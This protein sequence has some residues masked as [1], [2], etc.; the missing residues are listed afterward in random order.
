MIRTVLYIALKLICLTAGLLFLFPLID[1]SVPENSQ[2]DMTVLPDYNYM[3]DAWDML[4]E[5]K[6]QS[7][8]ELCGDII[9]ND[10]PGA[11]EAK[12]VYKLCDAEITGAKQRIYRVANGFVTGSGKSIE[13]AGGAVISDLIIYGDVRDLAIQGYYKVT[14]KETDLFIV[15]LSSIG[16]ATELVCWA[17]WMP[18]MLKAFRKAGA[19]TETFA[20]SVMKAMKK[21][22]KGGKTDLATRKLFTDFS[23]LVRTNSFPRSAY[24]LR[25]VDTPNDLAVYANVAVKSHSLPYLLLRSGGE[26]G[27]ALLRQY[28]GSETGIRVLRLCA[29]KGPA[30]VHW[31]RSY[32]PYRP[33][34]W[35]AHAAKVLYLNHAY[36]FIYHAAKDSR[37]SIRTAL[38]AIS[39]LLILIGL[40][41]CWDFRSLRR[42]TAKP[43]EPQT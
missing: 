33:M 42:G 38:Y 7:A 36:D 28:G 2:P 26:N 41:A 21:L 1:A 3:A 31:L 35:G 34:K 10:L 43:A 5:G 6:F 39:L 16:L 40:S 17:D 13:E 8:K 11:E 23:T 4:R 12:A 29:R 37:C 9:R 25:Y 20:Q 18:A 27:A 14:G 24:I 32:V 19:L 30:G 15:A 22:I